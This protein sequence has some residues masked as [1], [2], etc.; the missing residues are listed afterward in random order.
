MKR[1]YP[2]RL[3]V[4]LLGTALVALPAQGDEPAVDT[5]PA[6]AED[7]VPEARS[8]DDRLSEI[9]RRIQAAIEYPV[10][11]R[12]QGIEGETLVRFEIDRR[13]LAREIRVVR[14]SGI[15]RLDAAAE[16]AVVRAGRLPWVWGPL[17][18]PVRFDLQRADGDAARR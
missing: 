2:Q 14:S 4:A 5:A 8:V 18:V 9:R 7:A 13:G 12:W 3:A 1:S 11:A 6:R 17:E 16:R 15:A 10:L